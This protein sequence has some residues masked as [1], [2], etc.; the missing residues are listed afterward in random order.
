MAKASP[1]DFQ[2]WVV[3]NGF[4]ESLDEGNKF[5]SLVVDWQRTSWEYD[6]IEF[7]VVLDWRVLLFED[8]E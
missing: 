4:L 1:Q 7:H 8:I 3:L 5:R 6:S 2:F